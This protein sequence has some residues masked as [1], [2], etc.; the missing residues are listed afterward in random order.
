[1]SRGQNAVLIGCPSV[2]Q[3]LSFLGLRGDSAVLATDMEK[4]PDIMLRLIL[5]TRVAAVTAAD[6][7]S[8]LAVPSRHPL[9]ERTENTAAPPPPPPTGET[10]VE[11]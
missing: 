5:N 3:W 1:M 11:F 9:Y 10:P 8:A 6:Q 2:R 4:H 7:Q